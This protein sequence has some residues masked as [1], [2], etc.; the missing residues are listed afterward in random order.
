MNQSPFRQ[1]LSSQPPEG[2]QVPVR[3]QQAVSKKSRTM[4]VKVKVALMGATVLLIAVIISSCGTALSSLQAETLAVVPSLSGAALPIFVGG[5]LA[6]GFDMGVNTSG[7]LTNWVTVRN[8]AICMTYPRGQ[9]WGAVFITVGMP[10][11]PPRPGKDL[12]R[13]H[14]LSLELRG[15]VGSQSVSIGIKDKNQPDNG[16]ETKVLVS[17]LTTS[18]R[19]FAFPL[20]KFKCANL[21]QLYVVIEFVFANKPESVCA[22][23]IQYLL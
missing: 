9:S 2:Q 15:Q 16:S 20:S 1:Q 12:S 23:N 18:W 14:Q 3:S 21:H 22:R 13:Y 11:Q 19:P 10:T 7:G 5:Q 6:P 4:R 17:H 8:G